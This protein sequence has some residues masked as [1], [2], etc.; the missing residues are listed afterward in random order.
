MLGEEDQR[1]TKRDGPGHKRS[2]CPRLKK[3][4][5]QKGNFHAQQLGQGSQGPVNRFQGRVGTSGKAAQPQQQKATG[6]VFS[7]EGEE[8]EDP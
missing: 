5:G 6:R 1:E 7:L 2:E 8:V 3:G 4:I